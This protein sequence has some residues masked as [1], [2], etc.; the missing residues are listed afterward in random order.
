ML[1][2]AYYFR[3]YDFT[4]MHVND[5]YY[6]NTIVDGALYSIQVRYLGNETTTDNAGKSYSCSK[7]SVSTIKGN[8]FNG[9][10]RITMWL[11][12]D[13]AKIPVRVSSKI[14]IG[15]INVELMSAAGVVK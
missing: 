8:V 7:F 13:A 2:A 6:L 14:R 1:S 11:S 10:E 15:E 9:D 3:E 12:R 4:K 5:M